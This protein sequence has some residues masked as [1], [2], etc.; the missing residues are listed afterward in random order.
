M[1]EEFQ[2]TKSRENVEYEAFKEKL[3]N[4][5]RN[6]IP[7]KFQCYNLKELV[8]KDICK[9]AGMKKILDAIEG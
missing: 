9:E 7:L 5:L 8:S 6:N 4:M 3:D 2:L 1:G